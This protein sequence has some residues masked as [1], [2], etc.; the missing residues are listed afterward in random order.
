[1][2]QTMNFQMQCF[3]LEKMNLFN[4][5]FENL[6][7]RQ[8]SYINLYALYFSKFK[9]WQDVKFLIQTLKYTLLLRF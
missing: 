5:L 7:R 6:M 2:I 3:F 9:T 1:M 8:V 4:N